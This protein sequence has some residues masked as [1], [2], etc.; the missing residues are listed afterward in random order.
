MGR[1]A[2][3]VLGL[4]VGERRVGVSIGDPT[5]L[6][7]TP[8]TTITRSSLD[9][10]IASI[11]DLARE[12]EAAEIVV[13]MPLSLSSE[14]GPQARATRHF[15]RALSERTDIPVK[16]WDERFSTREAE[17]RLQEAGVKP[18]R[19]KG[20]LDAAAATVILQSYL[21]SRRRSP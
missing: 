3:R 14:V 2:L 7:A 12:N 1:E 4:D 5:G 10:D 21:D 17:R 9:L 11:L 13:G 16:R 8:L 19:D 20:R 15:I 6:L 18:S